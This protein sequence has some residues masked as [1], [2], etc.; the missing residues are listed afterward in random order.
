MNTEQK[1]IDTKIEKNHATVTLQKGQILNG[2]AFLLSVRMGPEIKPQLADPLAIG[3][4]I[5]FLLFV[6]GLIVFKRYSV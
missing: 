6:V 1:R 4:F 2:P 3:I 5:A